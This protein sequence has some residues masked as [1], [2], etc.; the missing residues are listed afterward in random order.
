[1]VVV[2]IWWYCVIVIVIG[3]FLLWLVGYTCADFSVQFSLCLKK[4]QG[5]DLE[6]LVWKWKLP[7]EHLLQLVLGHELAQ[8]GHKQRGTG[9]IGRNLR[10]G[11]V[12]GVVGGPGRT[13]QRRTRQIVVVRGSSGR[14]G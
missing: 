5:L 11:R 2:V 10:I 8:I 1:V 13:G 14:S 6:S 4:I 3:W 7:R 9:R 12:A